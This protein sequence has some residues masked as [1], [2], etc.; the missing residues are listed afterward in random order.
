[1]NKSPSHFM[2]VYDSQ[3][4]SSDLVLSHLTIMIIVQLSDGVFGFFFLHLYICYHISWYKRNSAKRKFKN[5]VQSPFK[6]IHK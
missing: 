3:N 5:I 4:E 6:Y 1:M 2:Y